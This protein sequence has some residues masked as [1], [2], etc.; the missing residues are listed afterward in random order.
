MNSTD[1]AVRDIGLIWDN[2]YATH[3]FIV[4]TVRYSSSWMEVS[5]KLQMF[6][7]K[8]ID[9]VLSEFSERLI[10]VQVISQQVNYHP[11]D[12]F[13]ELARDY[14]REYTREKSA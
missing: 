12:V 1:Q 4:D 11:R 2:D 13:D 14:W 8:S 10:G 7:E 6:Y 9:Y 3:Q 5:S